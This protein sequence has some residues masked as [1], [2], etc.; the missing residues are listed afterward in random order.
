[1]SAS[2]DNEEPDGS[3]AID[4]EELQDAVEDLSKAESSQSIKRIKRRGGNL[5]QSQDGESKS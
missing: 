1:L 5:S 3:N 2:E 4:E